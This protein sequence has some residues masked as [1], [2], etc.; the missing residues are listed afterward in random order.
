MV[1]PRIKYHKP[2]PMTW[3]SVYLSKIRGLWHWVTPTLAES[4]RF[5]GYLSKFLDIK[6]SEVPNGLS[7]FSKVL[8]RHGGDGVSSFFVVLSWDEPSKDRDFAW[9]WK[10]N[11]LTTDGYSGCFARQQNDD[12]CEPDGK[13]KHIF[14]GPVLFKCV[15]IFCWP[16]YPYIPIADGQDGF[17]YMVD[18]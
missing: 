4:A 13:R 17:S 8:L 6:F 11:L 1:K 16:Q 9:F 10:Q 15:H 5:P 12:M 14:K 18:L 3:N 7:A 2:S